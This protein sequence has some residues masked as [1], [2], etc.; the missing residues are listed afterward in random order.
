MMISFLMN[1]TR[2]NTYQLGNYVD[3]LKQCH[4]DDN[5]VCVIIIIYWL[6]R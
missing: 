3:F 1:T 6:I 5:S 4:F 2:H